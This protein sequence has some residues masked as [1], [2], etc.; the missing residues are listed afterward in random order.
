[1]GFDACPFQLKQR[2]ELLPLF[3]FFLTLPLEPLL[4]LLLEELLLEDVPDFDTVDLLLLVLVA[5]PE[6]PLGRL[7]DVLR[8]ILLFN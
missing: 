1:M 4:D 5:R 3:Y 6:L 8:I 2:K 7:N